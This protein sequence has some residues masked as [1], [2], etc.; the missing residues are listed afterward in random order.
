MYKCQKCNSTDV[1]ALQ[2]VDL[3][4]GE[5]DQES[6]LQEFYCRSCGAHTDVEY[7]QGQWDIDDDDLDV[8]A[9]HTAKPNINPEIE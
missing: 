6:D 7:V 3:N 2:W 9:T 4:T 8:S 1:E 5:A